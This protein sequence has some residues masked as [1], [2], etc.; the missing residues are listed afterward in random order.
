MFLGRSSKV[1][2][3][4]VSVCIWAE[5]ISDPCSFNLSEARI[6]FANRSLKFHVMEY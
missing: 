4:F 3:F 2:Q 6:G 5:G 1:L